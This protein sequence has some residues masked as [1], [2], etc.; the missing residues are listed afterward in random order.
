MRTEKVRSADGV[1]LAVYEVG[2]ADAPAILFIHGYAQSHLSWA[3]QIDSALTDKFRLICF[4]NR[5][6]GA[7]DKPLEASRYNQSAPWAGDVSAVIES[8]HLGR[9]VLVGWSYGGLII[10]DYLAEY[11]QAT[12]SGI[13][14]VA[15]AVGRGPAIAPLLKESQVPGLVPLMIST[16]LSSFI[17][18]TRKFLRL[19]FERPP[20]EAEF[21]VMLA[22]N[23]MVPAAVRAAMFDRVVDRDEVIA[24]LELPVLVSQGR[25]D[26]A[27]PRAAEK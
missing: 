24:A 4:D 26:A 15:A 5:G 12:I 22:Y 20:S 10:N 19:C 6:H 25:Q 13:N 9:P 7:S 18:G 27:V 17:D 2:P 21:E 1:E 11:G 8:L 3:R 16:D 23:A 14:Y